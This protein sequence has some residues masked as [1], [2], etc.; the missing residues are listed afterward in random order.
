[1]RSFG[2][3]G[4]THVFPVAVQLVHAPPCLPQ[5]IESLPATQVFPLQ[6]PPQFC[7]PH[8]GVPWHEP[9]PLGLNA[10]TCP[11]AVQLWQAWPVVPQA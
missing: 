7:G 5:A 6:Q 3:P 8:V 2:S 4:P 11:I 10:Q 9:P 1:M